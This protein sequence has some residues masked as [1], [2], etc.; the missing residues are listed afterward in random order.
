M[1]FQVVQGTPYIGWFPISTTDTIYVGQI[2][3]IGRLQGVTPLGTSTVFAGNNTFTK[4]W[5]VV[6]G[7]SA[8]TPTFDSTYKC[9]KITAVDPH[10]SAANNTNDN[11]MAET[12][13][14]RNDPQMYVQ[15]ALISPETVLKGNICNGTFG[16]A[17]SV[18]TVSTGNTTGGGFTATKFIDVAPLAYCHTIYCRSGANRGVYRVGNGTSQTV[19]TVLS[20][21]FPYDI[22]IGDTMVGVPFRPFG[23][24]N[25]Q[26]DSESMFIDCANN[27]SAAGWPV[28]MLRVDLSTAGEEWAM[29]MFN[30][31]SLAAGLAGAAW[32]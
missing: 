7:S 9:E 8:A 15:V 5:G 13:N 32:A 3:Q 2:V 26:F 22:A 20:P 30:P 1:G 25:V 21:F 19:S 6:V 16:T 10:A 31:T 4:P 12:L 17:P 28:N 27:C 18:G 24:T 14:P 23:Q 11:R 29:F